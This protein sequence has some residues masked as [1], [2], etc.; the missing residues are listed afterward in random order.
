M[1]TILAESQ[2]LSGM[3]TGLQVESPFPAVRSAD[4]KGGSAEPGELFGQ[5]VGQ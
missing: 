5:G 2:K 1:R 4:E 3:L